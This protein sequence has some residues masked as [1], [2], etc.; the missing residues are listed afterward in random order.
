MCICGCVSAIVLILLKSC[1]QRQNECNDTD[2]NDCWDKN[3]KFSLNIAISTLHK[4][5]Q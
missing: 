5:N 4:F 1:Y 2:K 3:F